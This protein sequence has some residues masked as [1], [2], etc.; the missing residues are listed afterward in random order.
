MTTVISQFVVLSELK[1]AGQTNLKKKKV[2]IDGNLTK[3]SLCGL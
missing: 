3:E 2:P 1:G